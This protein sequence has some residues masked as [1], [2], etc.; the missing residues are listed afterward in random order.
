MG[1][2]ILLFVLDAVIGFVAVLLLGRAY[3]QWARVSLRN[4]LGHFVTALTDW[5]VLPLRRV[6]PSVLGLDLAS[7]LPAWLL[8]SLLALA[9]FWMRGFGFGESG[10][11]AAMAILA[12]GFIETVRLFVFLIFGI[13]LITA[14]MS[15]IGPGSPLA[16]TLNALARPFLKPIRRIVPTISNIDLSP[17]VLLLLLQIALMLLATLRGGLVPSL[18]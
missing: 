9:E 17:L 13:V 5:L 15:W 11:V 12:I 4:D 6:L 18:T 16:P 3:M 2:N 14:I 7:V 8:Q 1:G 10:A